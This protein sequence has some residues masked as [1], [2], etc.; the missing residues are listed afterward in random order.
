[1]WV[2]TNITCIVSFIMPKNVVYFKRK[3]PFAPMNYN[4]LALF[5]Y[6]LLTA[7]L[8]PHKLPFCVQNPISSVKVVN[9]NGQSDNAL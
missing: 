4:A 2:F 7:L 3:L 6:E 9:S 8:C 1:M 5:P